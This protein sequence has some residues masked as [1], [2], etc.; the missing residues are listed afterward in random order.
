MARVIL[1]PATTVTETVEGASVRT[2]ILGDFALSL[3]ATAVDATT[4][5][6]KYLVTV[7]ETPDPSNVADADANWFLLSSFTLVTAAGT[8]TEKK[9]VTDPH[10]SRFKVRISIE[11]TTPTANIKVLAEGVVV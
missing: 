3:I 6:E 7:Y 8:T 10:F 4:G 2:G 5:D 9:T 11:G 1:Y